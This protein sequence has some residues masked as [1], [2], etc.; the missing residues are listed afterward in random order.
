MRRILPRACLALC[1]APLIAGAEPWPAGPAWDFSLPALD[2][3]RFVRLAAL[4]GPVLVN[5]WS[6]DC[7]PCVT[8]LPRLQRFADAH[9]AWT[10]LLVSTDSPAA[11]TEFVQRQGVR[12]PVLR[13]GA[14]VAALMRAAGNRGGALPFTVATRI[15]RICA[16]QLGALSGADLQRIARGCEAAPAKPAATT[17]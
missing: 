15:G 4:P 13:P 1:A 17:R 7:P 16:G 2:G 11:A 8:E 12:L 10:V 6:R 9:P 3:G 14:N 5:F